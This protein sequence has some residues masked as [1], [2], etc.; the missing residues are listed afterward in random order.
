MEKT[1][2]ITNKA[3]VKAEGKLNSKHCKPVIAIAIDGSEIRSFT[4]IDD[5]ARELGIQRNYMSKCKSENKPCNGYRICDTKDA[6][7]LVNEMMH[8]L[9][10]NASDAKEY[11]KIKAAE[12][13]KRLEEQKRKD[14]LAKAEAH[15]D[16]RKA[17]YERLVAETN[18]AYDLY[19]QAE[20]EL[21]AM[22]EEDGVA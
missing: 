2:V 16:R 1:I 19:I 15:A 17:I 11:R 4:S 12:E 8:A 21:Q 22:R 14:A 3:T 7:I 6:A 20:K 5:A 18:R 9:N 10:K 13:A